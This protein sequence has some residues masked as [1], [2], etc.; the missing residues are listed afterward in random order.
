[1]LRYKFS[2]GTLYSFYCI[3]RS[4]S[5]LGSGWT[6]WSGMA[7]INGC[8]NIRSVEPFE[9]LS[10]KN[11]VKLPRSEIHPMQLH[12]T[13]PIQLLSTLYPPPPPPTKEPQPT[14]PAPSTQ[15]FSSPNIT[16]IYTLITSPSNPHKT[17]PNLMIA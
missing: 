14:S 7:Q 16:P 15:G 3:P 17:T 10:L 12:N 5:G 2:V 8:M 6:L 11:V 13:N 4:L 9:F 1:M